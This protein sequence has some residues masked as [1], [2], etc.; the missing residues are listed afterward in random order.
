MSAAQ[1]LFGHNAQINP[2]VGPTA[3]PELH[4]RRQSIFQKAKDTLSGNGDFIIHRAVLV[5]MVFII[6]MCIIWFAVS[7][8]SFSVANPTYINNKGEEQ[9]VP[10][11]VNGMYFA[12]TTLS[13]TGYGDIC[14]RST[15]SK[16]II[17]IVQAFVTVVSIGLLWSLNDSRIK[18]MLHQHGNR[19]I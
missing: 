12:L 6:I 8:N 1:Q 14:P 3:G 13:T 15:I 2:N 4:I 7:P 18:R 10:D 9:K 17:A 11:A 16:S 19:N 5:I